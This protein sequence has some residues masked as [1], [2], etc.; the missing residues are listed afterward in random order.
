VQKLLNK[1][2]GMLSGMGK[3]TASAIG[4]IDKLERNGEKPSVRQS[5]KSIRQ[6]QTGGHAATEKVPQDKAR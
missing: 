3:I 4:K 2:G 5:L 1:T 6:S